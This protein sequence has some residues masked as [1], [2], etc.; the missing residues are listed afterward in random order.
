MRWCFKMIRSL[1]RR[2]R[3]RRRREL[4]IENHRLRATL[5]GLE[6]SDDITLETLANALDLKHSKRVTAFTI[7]IARL[8]SL[9]NDEIRTIAQGAFL[10]DIGKMAVPDRILLK[11]GKLTPE[12]VSVIREQVLYGYKLLKS[13]PFLQEAAEIVYS[14]HERYD[15]SGYPR[16]LKGD[17]IPLGAR[18]VT[19]ANTLDSLTSDLSVRAAQTFDAAR[20]EIEV[21]SGRQFDPRIVKLFLEMP[22]TLW[23][24]LRH[25]LL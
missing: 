8:M 23:K 10:H 3:L 19:V 17:E 18:I 7:A 20:R 21:G 9:P 4:A 15:G 12:E 24:D 16:G 11:P 25:A 5:S 1:L 2:R 22:D 6:K 13:I 14:H